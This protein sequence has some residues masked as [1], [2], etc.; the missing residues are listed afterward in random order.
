M[1][2]RPSLHSG[3]HSGLQPG[4]QSGRGARLRFPIWLLLMLLGVCPPLAAQVALAP[5]APKTYV[6]QPGD[7]L[8]D[9]AGRFLRDPWR[10]RDVWQANPDV[11]NPNRIFPGDV[12]EL[13][14]EGGNP[15]IRTVRGGGG[16]R[17]VKLTPRV[18][19]TELDRAIPTIP[20][21]AVAPFLS[22]PVVTEAREIDKA[23]YVVGFP[24]SHLMAGTGG[25][26]FVRSI[27]GGETDRYEVLR[28]GQ[29]YRDP[30]TNRVLGFEASYVASAR[31]ER[32]GDPATLVVTRS[33]KEVE[34]GD[35]VRPARDEEPIRSFF[36]V[37]APTGLQGRIIAVLNGVT[38]IGQFDVVVLNRGSKQ[39]VEVGHVFEVY[40]GGDLR[41][42]QVR[43]NRAGWNWRNETPLDTS[44]W[45]GDWELDGW[46]RDNPNSKAPIPLHRRAVRNSDQ[47]IVP[48]SRSGVIMVFRVFPEVSFALVMRAIRAM[49]VG[50]MVSA[51]REL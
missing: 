25:T 37:P 34:I 39:Q 26:I 40:Q 29:E 9:I 49:H 42:D 12:L 30:D 10:W 7:T 47:Y 14:Y 32:T 48:D 5:N 15:R 23:P 28:P 44:F 13:V 1:T 8:W 20:V 46:N 45:Y 24:E 31:L 11:R 35:R 43:S 3:L 17:T 22:R 2:T 27:L 6:V 33:R 21:N 16:M 18:R 41:R 51:P 38:Q 36:P 4:L 19:V 50:E